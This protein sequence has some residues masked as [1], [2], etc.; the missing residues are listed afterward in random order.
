MMAGNGTDRA[1]G[2]DDGS[3]RH[4]PVLLDEIL[5]AF[6]PVVSG[7]VADKAPW[8]IDGT[9]GAGGYSSALLQLGRAHVLAIDQDPAVQAVAE[10]LS[11]AADGRF[12]FAA[13]NF[14]TLDTH[15]IAAGVPTVAGVV[16]DIGVSSMQLD[17]ALR[18]F[19]FMRDGPLDMRMGQ[20]G[21]SAA[22]VVNEATPAEL[23]AIIRQ[24]GEE[25]R[26]GAIVRAITARRTAAR[27]ETTGAL[28]ELIVDA[29]GQRKGD[30]RHPATRTFQ[31]LRIY[32]NDELAALADGLHA[33]ERILA[34]GGRLAVVSFHSLEDRIVKR[35][36]KSRSDR[37]PRASRH[38]PEASNTPAES[39]RI[40]N[41]NPVLPGVAELERNPRARSAVL[42]IAERTE[43]PA[44][45]RAHERLGLP[46]IARPVR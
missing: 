13:G 30:E 9:F 14:R 6:R 35:F 4:I 28:A 27:I 7:P 2:A 45:A 33:A 16:L 21:R 11:A 39:F 23:I 31:A 12:T 10:Q 43:A 44:V 20:A 22:D 36:L 15:A 29:V 1:A 34:P 5:D 42:R 26:A 37:A 46:G 32:V 8:I 19:S 24:L 3:P 18:G 40:L 17:Q 25:K 41:P 38:Q